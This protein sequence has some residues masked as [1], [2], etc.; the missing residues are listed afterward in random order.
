MPTRRPRKPS[1]PTKSPSSRPSRS[2]REP[3]YEEEERPSRRSKRAP[4]TEEVSPVAYMGIAL[5]VIL[6]L[7]IGYMV[8]IGGQEDYSE[9]LKKEQAK[10][11]EKEKK[12]IALFS[13][14]KGKNPDTKEKDPSKTTETSES[15]TSSLFADEEL[16]RKRKEEE[17][18]LKAEEEAEK[19]KAEAKI[20]AEEEAKKAGEIP[21]FFDFLPDTSI[22][23]KTKI[24]GLCE[25]LVGDNYRDSDTARGELIQIGTKALPMLINALKAE[26]VR[27]DEGGI[28]GNVI[29]QTLEE[30][31]VQDIGYEGIASPASRQGAKTKW[32]E[33]WNNERKKYEK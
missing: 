21:E 30:I 25:Q 1:R 32:I 16:E 20:K 28:R 33:W 26:D 22:G 24:K 10:A 19:A 12:E 14:N 15:E 17:A 13:L 9:K 31:A 4:K 18:K 6:L 8:I 7:S 11:E 5:A 27:S 3:Q 23:D 2:S 29:A